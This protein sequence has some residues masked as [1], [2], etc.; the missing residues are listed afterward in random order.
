M[1]TISGRWMRLLLALVLLGAMTLTLRHDSAASPRAQSGG[2][3]YFDSITANGDV[4][5][6]GTGVIRDTK[7][8]SVQAMVTSG[9]WNLMATAGGSPNIYGGVT[10]NAISSGTYGGFIGGGGTNTTGVWGGAP[11][12]N[13]IATNSHFASIVGGLNNSIYA[14]YAA[15]GGGHSNVIQ[16]PG[17]Y[18]AIGGGMSNEINGNLGTIAGGYDNWIKTGGWSFIGGGSGNDTNG[19]INTIAGGVDNWSNT[20]AYTFIG[21]GAYNSI[22]SG[23]VVKNGSYM[24]TATGITRRFP[25]DYLFYMNGPSY[26]D[27]SVIG[28]GF[29][30]GVS[31]PL[32]FIGGGGEN[33]SI[34]M[35]TR[36]V[37]SPYQLVE[38]Q[39]G[40]YTSTI[41]I[42]CPSR[43][44]V[45]TGG[46]WNEI[47]NA[48]VAPVEGLVNTWCQTSGYAVIGG[49]Y[50]NTITGTVAQGTTIAGGIGNTITGTYG[51]VGGGITNTVSGLYG[52]VPGGRLNSVT[53]NY[54]FAA[55]Y[56]AT[57]AHRGAFVWADSTDAAYQSVAPDS[58]NVRASGGVTLTTSGAGLAL[59]G[60]VIVDGMAFTY[61]APITITGVLTNVRLL[62]YQVP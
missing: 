32:S 25:I 49:G 19:S 33:W 45:I 27:Y 11:L 10:G 29:M 23:D 16:S 13:T 36:T 43:Y 40:C 14:R 15:I 59:D 20:G 12:F 44:N 28:G 3:T 53:A 50:L 37:T 62:F 55:G 51:T 7:D 41:T 54:G 39:N 4:D 17:Y 48:Y 46:R 52:T 2:G 8:Q 26:G 6:W 56:R 22:G 38:D 61:T 58:F 5:I 9:G 18:S 21:G 42:R 47:N 34:S 60:P 30:N 31:D 24:I 1:R 35:Y 57:A